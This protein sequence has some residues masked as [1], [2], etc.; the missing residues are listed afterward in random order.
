MR[1]FHVLGKPLFADYF[2]SNKVWWAIMEH[3][4]HPVLDVIGWKRWRFEYRML[5]EFNR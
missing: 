5:E 3:V 4:K 2:Q 1:E